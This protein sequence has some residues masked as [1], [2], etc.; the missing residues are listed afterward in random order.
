VFHSAGVR[1][2]GRRHLKAYWH[3]ANCCEKLAVNELA[4]VAIA[5]ILICV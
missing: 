3:V 1:W 4:L 5:A 2:I